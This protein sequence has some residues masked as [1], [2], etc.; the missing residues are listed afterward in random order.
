MVYQVNAHLDLCLRTKTCVLH[1]LIG[2]RHQWTVAG[3]RNLDPKG[4]RY[5]D[6]KP[7]RTDTKS[8]VAHVNLPSR[9]PSQANPRS[10]AIY[11]SAGRTAPIPGLSPGVAITMP[12]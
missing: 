2:A 3:E 4:Q 9:A 1:D 5:D 10:D 7:S 6:D 8:S 12:A 11:R